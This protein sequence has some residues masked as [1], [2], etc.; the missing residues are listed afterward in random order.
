MIAEI[1]VFPVGKGIHLS[2]YV[3]QVLPLIEQSGL[4]YK[5]TP[6]GTVVEG[7]ADLVFDLIKAC[8]KKMAQIADRVITN[9]KIDDFKGRTGCIKQKIAS[10][11]NKLGHELNK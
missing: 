6:M 11:E 7:D 10:V 2:K 5:M 8:H 9:V 3:S 4:A 1:S